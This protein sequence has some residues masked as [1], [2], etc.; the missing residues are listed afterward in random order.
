MSR[1]FDKR[2]AALEKDLHRPLP[3]KI[4]IYPR[5]YADGRPL[6]PEIKA[7]YKR[8][9]TQEEAMEYWL[10]KGDEE[11]VFL[12]PEEYERHFGYRPER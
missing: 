10:L 11:H 5:Y 2:L 12:S 4:P 9:L 1:K 3:L 6:P 7:K 8:G